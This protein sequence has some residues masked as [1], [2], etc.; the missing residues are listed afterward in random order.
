MPT[1]NLQI[2][3]NFLQNRVG[4]RR[5]FRSLHGFTQSS[6]RPFVTRCFNSECSLLFQLHCVPITT[7]SF[8]NHPIFKNFSLGDPYSSDP[9]KRACKPCL[10]KLPPCTLLL[11]LHAYLFFWI[12]SRGDCERQ[13]SNQL[14]QHIFQR[15]LQ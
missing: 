9:N 12:F 2:R 3:P 6:P 4:L 7:V 14:T 5:K 10:T 8:Q 11:G 13:S 1:C 15:H